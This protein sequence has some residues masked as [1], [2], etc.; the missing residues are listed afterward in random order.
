VHCV[1]FYCVFV[2]M[3]VLCVDAHTCECFDEHLCNCSRALLRVHVHLCCNVFTCLVACACAFVLQC[4]QVYGN[5][6]KA[7]DH[8]HQT[9]QLTYVHTHTQTHTHTYT[10]THKRPSYPPQA[11]W[12]LLEDFVPIEAF[13]HGKDPRSV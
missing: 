5:V 8:R 4:R 11:W 6:M 1:R 10:H 3:C 9:H 12:T 7:W 2:C 13:K